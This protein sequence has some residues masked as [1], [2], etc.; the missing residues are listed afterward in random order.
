MTAP[1][2]A[3][4]PDGWLTGVGRLITGDPYNIQTRDHLGNE[5][6]DPKKMKFFV[7]I[8]FSKTDPNTKFNEAWA[9]MQQ[10]GEKHAQGAQFKA[11]GW[12]GFHF[13]MD[14]GDQ[15][16]FKDKLGYP[17]HWIL[18]CSNGFQPRLYDETQANVQNDPTSIYKGCYVRAFL[19]AKPNTGVNGQ[20]GI[21]LNVTMIQRCGH[22]APIQSGPDFTQML[23][24]N[25]IALPVGASATPLAPLGAPAGLPAA[26]G[27]PTGLPAGLPPTGVPASTGLPAGLPP[28]GAPAGISLPAGVP[29]GVP[30]GLPGIGTPTALGAPPLGAPPVTP[31]T[32]QSFMVDPNQ[33]YDAAITAGWTDETLIAAGHMRHPYAQ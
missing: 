25:A 21:Y 4:G 12:A 5:I 7:A 6:T 18:K 32:K 28:T 9:Y 3:E 17:G 26:S 16:Q 22:G 20:A 10:A 29:A 24:Q 13:K 1:V 23:S 15:P 31:P 8:A 27:V 2:I 19:S 30:V 11:A 33:S 14:D